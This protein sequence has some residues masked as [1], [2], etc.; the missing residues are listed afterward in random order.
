M[1]RIILGV[2]VGFVVWTILWLGSDKVL[3]SLSPAWYGSHQLT[4]EGALMTGTGFTPDPTILLIHIVR[5]S[6]ISIMSGFIAAMV[7]GE[8][9]K[10]PLALGVVLLLVGVAVEA[11]AWNYL[12]IWYHLIFLVLII[13]MTLLGGRMKQTA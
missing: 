9:R 8:N 6:I 4:F 10:T 2:I 12:P 5:A 11:M 3:M 7:A 13:P 1:V